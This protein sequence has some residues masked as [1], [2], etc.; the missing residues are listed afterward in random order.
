MDKCRK[1]RTKD[2][3]VRMKRSI[4]FYRVKEDLRIL[5]LFLFWSDD[6]QPV[7]RVTYSSVLS[8]EE[9][10][11]QQS[12]PCVISISCWVQMEKMPGMQHFFS[13]LISSYTIMT[14]MMIRVA[15]EKLFFDKKK[16]HKT[17]SGI[18]VRS[19]SNLMCVLFSLMYF[20]LLKSHKN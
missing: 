13:P 9:Y 17:S 10:Q 19:D 3:S 12:I 18:P 15:L 7:I 6:H 1:R 5:L 11:H 16:Y 2:C 14:T 8:V 20:Y 4:K